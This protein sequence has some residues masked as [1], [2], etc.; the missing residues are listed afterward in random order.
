MIFSNGEWF[1]PTFEKWLEP[2]G[3]YIH[4]YND[5]V[6][7]T[8]SGGEI[9]FPVSE[10]DGWFVVSHGDRGT[11]EGPQIRART[12]VDVQRYLANDLSSEV[13][14][15]LGL[16]WISLPGKPGGEAPG[17]QVVE[18][19]DRWRSLERADG[20]RVQVDLRGGGG[21]NRAVEF[22]W[23]A[24]RPLEVVLSSFAAPDGG[25]LFKD[26]LWYGPET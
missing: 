22:S 4:V 13:R 17:Y 8:E 3:Y 9:R 20:S 5:N 25:P 23:V 7:V 19:G 24:D 6:M 26:F 18:L 15:G 12:L 14:T 2:S 10:E 16:T 11:D 21:T 1:D